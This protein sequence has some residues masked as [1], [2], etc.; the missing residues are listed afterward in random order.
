M[1]LLETP[2][3]VSLLINSVLAIWLFYNSKFWPAQQQ[4]REID[5]AFNIKTKA[6][7]FTQVLE[8]N[9]SLVDNL[10][11]RSKLETRIAEI[12]LTMMAQFEMLRK[13]I[14]TL[15]EDFSHQSRDVDKHIKEIEA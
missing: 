11:E 8:I 2:T 12:E 14:G 6:E 4:Q 10:I 15:R 5:Q 13:E 3:L 9:R 1:I 7:A